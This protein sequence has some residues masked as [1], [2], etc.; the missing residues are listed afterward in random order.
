M[1]FHSLFDALSATS[2]SNGA[3]GRLPRRSIR[4]HFS[5]RRM[6]P[7]L[8][9]LEDRTV[10]TV[11]NVGAG[12]VATLIKD[13]DTA[14]SNG[15]S[16]NII[17]L[18]KSTYDLK[19]ID[20]Y[21]YGPNGLPPIT[22]NLFIHGNGAV[23]QRDP[24]APSFRLFYVSGGM[25][26]PGGSLNMDNVT[27]EGGIAKGGDS[28]FGGG[29][30]G[31]G[32]AIFNQGTLNLLDVT[33]TGNV[34]QGGSSGVA[35]TNSF[36]GGGM[37]GDANG[38]TA[39]GFGGSIGLNIG[40]PFAGLGGDGASGGGG[41]GGGFVTGAD[42]ANATATGLGSGGG[43]GGFG[44]A[45][46][47]GGTGGTNL[48][49]NG[50]GGIGGAFGMGGGP[51]DGAGG[52]GVGGGGGGPGATLSEDNDGAGGGFGGGGGGGY[53]STFVT[54][55]G[56]TGGFGGGGGGSSIGQAGQPDNE[57]FGGGQG[58]SNPNG[59]AGGGG[60]AGMGGAIFNMGA[61]S[62]HLSGGATLIDCTLTGNSAVGGTASIASPYVAG[63]PGSGSGGA[64]FNLDGRVE[65]DNDTLAANTVGSSGDGGAVFNLAFGNDID[66]RGPV[67]A[68]LVLNNSILAT[69]T[70]GRDLSS[71]VGGFPGPDTATLSGS[72]NLVMS[73][74]I[75]PTPSGV[76]TQTANPNLGPLQNNGGLTPTM[77]PLPGSPVLGAG[78]PS[79]APTADQRGIPRPPGGPTDLG[80]VQVSVA[81]SPPAPSPPPTLQVPPLLAFIDAVLGGVEKVNSNGTETITDSLFGFPLIVATFNGAG[82]L[83]SVTLFGFNITFLFG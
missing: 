76:I 38:Q 60:G 29:G 36:A 31:A 12:D 13:I 47:D 82:N 56:G 53:G 51:G 57:G 3:H 7:C 49:A 25:E 70:G 73:N 45:G 34:A 15:Q 39:G 61:D 80:S 37:G 14:N 11:F 16:N 21:W 65:L 44:S 24:S 75:F 81:P 17:N 33:L 79:Q 28:E 54:G 77:L 62:A 63:S 10:P 66:S 20:N 68:S 6:R 67:T 83:V 8:E 23:I 71:Y 41:G 26:L 43:N 55:V 27:L 58:G 18:T 30:M 50:T 64:I 69:T 9:V 42:G 78:D 40:D 52:G 4:P 46:N 1:W 35:A 74:D 5:S 59:P 2:A 32:G 19:G 72:H 22:S 48:S